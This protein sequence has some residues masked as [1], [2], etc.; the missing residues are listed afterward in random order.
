MYV[1][2]VSQRDKKKSKY[3]LH[4]GYV[5]EAISYSLENNKYF[6]KHEIKIDRERHSELGEN[7]TIFDLEGAQFFKGPTEEEQK[8]MPSNDKFET[9][10]TEIVNDQME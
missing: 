3:K 2:R 9:V 1:Q 10:A 7:A 6:K 5:M 4:I 8:N